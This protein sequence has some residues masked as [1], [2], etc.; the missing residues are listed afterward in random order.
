MVDYRED[1]EYSK[2]VEKRKESTLSFICPKKHYVRK[3]GWL[4]IA[5]NRKEVVSSRVETQGYI[6]YFSLC[7]KEAIDVL[8]FEREGIIRA[9]ARGY[10]DVCYCDFVE[11]NPLEFAKLKETLGKT[12]GFNMRFEELVYD[13]SFQKLVQNEPFDVV[14][15][16]FC[17]SCFPKHDAP[18]SKTLRAIECVLKLQSAVS[19]NLFITFR[20]QRSSEN[21]GAIKELRDVMEKNLS[22][23]SDFKSVYEEKIGFP[24]NILCENDYPSF[25]LH[26]FPKILLG[27]GNNYNLGGECIRRFYYKRKEGEYKIVKFIF[28]F[29]PRRENNRFSD[30]SRKTVQLANAYHKSIINCLKNSPI[31]VDDVLTNKPSLRA[32]L[33]NDQEDLIKNRGKFKI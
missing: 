24:L 32:K 12:K 16:D 15:L 22:Q 8:L 27:F 7:G 18:D 13:G 6:R 21:S 2:K 14:N 26:T 23:F 17:G 20:A 1:I 31:N 11:D 28:S 10:P 4:T 19:F 30:R 5:R 25:L 29:E 33:N 3:E 9:N